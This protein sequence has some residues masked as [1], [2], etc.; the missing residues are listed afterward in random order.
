MNDIFDKIK[1]ELEYYLLE[2]SPEDDYERGFDIG[3]K[4]AI[5]V[6]D[7]VRQEQENTVTNDR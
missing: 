3:I 4:I 2:C 5:S 6:V 1:S 7:R